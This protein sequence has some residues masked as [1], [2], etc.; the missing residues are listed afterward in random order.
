MRTCAQ[1]TYPLNFDQVQRISGLVDRSPI[2]PEIRE[3]AVFGKAT[4]GLREVFLPFP[5]CSYLYHTINTA[6][7]CSYKHMTP[8]L[9]EA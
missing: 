6:I 7:S 3:H 5:C 2:I 8:V 1:G 4:L 9:L